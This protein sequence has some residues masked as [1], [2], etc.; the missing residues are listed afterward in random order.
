MG[1][2]PEAGPSMSAV[3]FGCFWGS[4]GHAGVDILMS[5]MAQGAQQLAGFEHPTCA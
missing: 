4:S 3:G 2:S 5:H 1:R